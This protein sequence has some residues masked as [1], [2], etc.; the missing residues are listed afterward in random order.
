MNL[1]NVSFLLPPCRGLFA[2]RLSSVRWLRPATVLRPRLLER[3]R[4]IHKKETSG[5]LLVHVVTDQAMSG[6]RKNRHPQSRRRDL[7]SRLFDR[8]TGTDVRRPDMGHVPRWVGAATTV[9]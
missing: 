5:R 7:P 9:W 3:Q 6:R 2:S 8:F 4:R 1:A